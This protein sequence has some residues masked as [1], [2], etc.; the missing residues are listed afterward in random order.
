MRAWMLLAASLLWA[1][2]ALIPRPEDAVRVFE[3]RLA[4]GLN[5]KDAA[6]VSRLLPFATEE[7]RKILQGAPPGAFRLMVKA[8]GTLDAGQ[9]VFVC[10]EDAQDE[11]AVRL[12]ALGELRSV[13]GRPVLVRRVPMSEAARAFRIASHRAAMRVEAETGVTETAESI[14]LLV[15]QPTRWV[16]FLLDPER[17][18]RAVSVAAQGADVVRFAN[19]V[20]VERAE[21]WPAGTRLQ[22][23]VR[24]RL[25]LARKKL[26]P[27]ASHPWSCSDFS[28]RRELPANGRRA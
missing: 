5:A 18:V 24:S 7:E 28:C 22:V 13:S 26:A 9:L 1:G 3:L 19:F 27:V 8:L 12:Q 11:P 4:A 16:F 2:V 15:L 14:E 25:R 6:E 20:C 23:E 21:N 17:E 10:V